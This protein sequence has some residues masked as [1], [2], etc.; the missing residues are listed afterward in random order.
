MSEGLEG[1]WQQSGF[2][3]LRKKIGTRNHTRRF[4]FRLEA[5]LPD[6]SD[7]VIRRQ[8]LRSVQQLNGQSIPVLARN[9]LD[10]LQL[11]R[12]IPVPGEQ[13]GQFFI[14]TVQLYIGEEVCHC[15]D[16]SL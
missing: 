9:L 3:R 5:Q 2:Q 6:K 10:V 8:I 7:T 12:L 13:S 4:N 15:W 16:H 11:D 14:D 1:I